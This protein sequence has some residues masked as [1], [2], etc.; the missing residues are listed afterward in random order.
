MADF[1]LGWMVAVLL[2][3]IFPMI[4]WGDKFFDQ[5][6]IECW[7]EIEE[8]GKKMISKEMQVVG[9]YKK[10]TFDK[11]R[12]MYK[13]HFRHNFKKFIVYSEYNIDEYLSH[14][15]L[16][17]Y[18][19]IL[20]MINAYLFERKLPEK[21][22]IEFDYTTGWKIYFG[23]K[24]LYQA[25]VT[26]VCSSFLITGFL[27]SAFAGFNFF[28][29][30][31]GGAIGVFISVVNT[32]LYDKG[33]LK[34]K[35][36]RETEETELVLFPTTPKYEIIDIYE[37]RGKKLT[38]VEKDDKPEREWKPFKTVI[39][40]YNKLQKMIN[41]DLYSELAYIKI[42][43]EKKL[44]SPQEVKQSQHSNLYQMRYLYNQLLNAKDNNRR[45]QVDNRD[46]FNRLAY[47]QETND[48]E[49][50]E[51]AM[52]I[53][54][55]QQRAGKTLKEMI[56]QIS[57]DQKIDLNWE[58]V[59]ERAITKVEESREDK[60]YD[61]LKYVSEIL[62]VLVQEV[63]KVIGDGIPQIE[64]NNLVKQLEIKEDD[65]LNEFERK[66]KR[67]NGEEGAAVKPK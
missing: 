52:D 53:I 25:N 6:I 42:D 44:R 48:Q 15:K 57:G 11:A 41:S 27:I 13:L 66:R 21:R 1:W 34:P 10:T 47:L 43:E 5:K 19:F 18:L 64:L 32:L 2:C 4:H 23:F 55:E 56:K 12:N 9:V 16:R 58:K 29:F 35:K 59:V 14:F 45:L 22:E 65:F 39:R 31:I 46:L 67:D 33:I 28:V 37:V 61:M 36:K 49:R 40:G 38:T 54:L 30:L 17:K 60:R 3:I 62:L 26:G 50:K 8:G 7:K 24:Y 63:R 20:Y 51:F